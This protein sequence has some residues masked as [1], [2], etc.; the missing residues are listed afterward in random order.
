[1]GSG[2]THSGHYMRMGERYIGYRSYDDDDDVHLTIYLS[3]GCYTNEATNET[4]I[5]DGTTTVLIDKN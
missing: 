4:E 2:M 5:V 3:L 1:M